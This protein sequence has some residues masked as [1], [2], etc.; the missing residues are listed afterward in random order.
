MKSI[1]VLTDFS[2]NATNASKGA[3][4]LAERKHAD[5]LLYNSF[6]KY[7]SIASYAGTSWKVDECIESKNHSKEQLKFLSEQLSSIDDRSVAGLRK[8]E[9]YTISEDNDLGS[10]VVRLINEYDIE[11]IVM[12]AR[13]PEGQ[14]GLFGRDIN[15]VIE[16]AVCP[17]LVL[18]GNF[19]LKSIS[20]IL[21]ASNY[22]E[23]DIIAL[24]YIVK[25]AE[26][27]NCDLEIVHINNDM[28]SAPGVNKKIKHFEE[29]LENTKFGSIKQNA[30]NGK[31]VINRLNRLLDNGNGDMLA[32]VHAQRSFF[33]RFF[34]HSTVK[35]AIANQ[36]APLLIFPLI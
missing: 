35:E 7:P 34:H 20:R 22:T 12:G 28:E 6:I 36:K 30:L 8:P 16:K 19:S 32:M 27:L 23:S 4:W 10:A 5:L 15:S 25:F 21:F 3:L 1:L 17:V 14:P 31:N 26:L 18:P 13:D 24:S 33:A 11:L 9:M 29:V 2:E